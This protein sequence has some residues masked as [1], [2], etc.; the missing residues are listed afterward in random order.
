MILN[1]ETLRLKNAVEAV[2]FACGEPIEI[3]KIAQAFA[4]S[5]EDIQEVLDM[6]IVEYEKRNGGFV[7]RRMDDSYQFLSQPTYVEDIRKVLDVRRNQPLSQAAF[8]VLAIVAYNQPVT[9][10]FI[11]QVRGVDCS[12]VIGTLCQR[13]LIEECGRLDLPGRP[14]LYCTTTSF[15]RCFCLS[16]LEE[17]PELPQD[18]DALA[19]MEGLSTTDGVLNGQIS[20]L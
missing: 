10:S 19:A 16:S 20:I 17:L 13:D 18:N 6:L 7:L 4:M 5:V 1:D 3:Q 15:L 11:E 14:L 2:V 9:K 8:E 12:G